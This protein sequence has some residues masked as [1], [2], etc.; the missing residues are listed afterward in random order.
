MNKEQERSTK[1]G[2]N[3]RCYTGTRMCPRVE[4]CPETRNK[5]FAATIIAVAT[6]TF[7]PIV[8]AIGIVLVIF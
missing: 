5:E 1:Y 4:F 6:V 2:C 3:G 8:V 7:A